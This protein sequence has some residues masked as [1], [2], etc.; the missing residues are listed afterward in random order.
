MTPHI[1][2]LLMATSSISLEKENSDSFCVLIHE[3]I[4][5]LLLSLF[6]SLKIYLWFEYPVSNIVPCTWAVRHW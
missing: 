2:C 6:I 5:Y 4:K 3:N 1:I